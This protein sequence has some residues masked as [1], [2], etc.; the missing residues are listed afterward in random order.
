MDVILDNY[1]EGDELEIRVGYFKDGTFHSTIS[2]DMFVYFYKYFNDRKLDIS[3][4]YSY[5]YMYRL[6]VS[7]GKI[8]TI[9]TLDEETTIYK[10]TKNKIDLLRSNMRIA[11][12]EEVEI[13]PCEI[14][15]ENSIMKKRG[16]HT[17]TKRGCNFK[18]DLTKDYYSNYTVNQMEIEFI[19]KPKLEEVYGVLN[20]LK[21]H[22]TNCERL[23][24]RFSLKN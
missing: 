23:N 5:V 12:S 1:S 15:K 2:E 10:R 19:N 14:Y 21:K 20:W 17:F 4:N 22:I 11:L 7:G 9:K 16:R 13:E 18:I 24:R 3:Y 6:A 8:K